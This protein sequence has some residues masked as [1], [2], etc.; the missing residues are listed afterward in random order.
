MGIISL[1]LVRGASPTA[2]DGRGRQVIHAATS[3]WIRTL[4]TE[5]SG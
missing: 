3:E 1:L 2:K 5:R 4:L